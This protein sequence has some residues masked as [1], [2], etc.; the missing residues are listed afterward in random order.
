MSARPLRLVQVG[1]GAMGRA[2]LRTITDNP[3]VQLVAL[4]DLDTAAAAQAAA[5]HD[6]TGIV[7][8]DSLDEAIARTAPDAVVDVTVP[9]AHS[10]VNITALRAGLPVLCEK[11]IAP[12]VAAAQEQARVS[13][14]TGRLLMTSQSRRYYTALARF[15]EQIRTLGALG[16]VSTRFFRAP[17]F[18]GFREEMQHVLLVDMAIHAFDALRYLT[19]R[20][21]VAVVCTESNPPWSWFAH[22]ASAVV[23]F[24]FADGSRYTYDGS[25]CAPG[26]ETSWN[27]DWF[28][29]GEHGSARWDGDGT[30]VLTG[31]AE[32]EH[33]AGSDREEIAGALEDFVDAVRTGRTPETE[34]HANIISLAMV[35]A[36]VLSAEEGRRVLLSEVLTG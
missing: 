14:E 24:E 31:P 34:V 2:W 5:N 23:V 17:H 25:W 35:E 26:E 29:S 7:I 30:P 12:T 19:G 18:G 33:V 3:D 10:E 22:G 28:V 32:P 11:P 1:A 4:V 6:V 16:A 21:P 9:A 13:T 15:R 8:T 36:A 27:G 20:D